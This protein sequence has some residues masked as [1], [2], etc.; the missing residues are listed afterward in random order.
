MAIKRERIEFKLLPE[1]KKRLQ[2]LAD[3]T[4]MPLSIFVRDII[5]KQITI[6]EAQEEKN[7]EENGE[8][9]DGL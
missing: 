2:A 6:L 7:K 1:Q 4:D 5:M 8:D 9:N 3:K